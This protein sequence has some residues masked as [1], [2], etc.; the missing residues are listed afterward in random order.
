[1]I[2]Y[3][4]KMENIKKLSVLVILLA[5]IIILTMQGCKKYSDG[6]FISLRT[7]TERVAHA[8]KI[9]SYTKNGADHTSTMVNYTET[10]TKDGNYSYSWNILGGTGKW[11]FQNNDKE[12]GLS[13]INNPAAQTRV[14]LKLEDTQFWY[15][16]MV[17]NDKNE[18]HMVR[19]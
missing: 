18:F 2:I 5:M 4:F 10:Y 15:Y 8:W 17:G 9:G 19:N 1:M 11:A 14:I 7:R 6:P 16:S 13:D 3:T 12:I